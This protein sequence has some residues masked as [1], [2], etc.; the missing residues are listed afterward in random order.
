MR[1]ERLLSILL[2]LQVHGRM[3]AKELARRLEVSERTIHRDMEAL[4]AAGVPVTAVRGTGGGWALLEG[5]ETELTGLNQEEVQALFLA[6]SSRA[7]QDLGMHQAWSAAQIR[8]MAALPESARRDAEFVRQRILV[9]GAPRSYRVSRVKGATVTAEPAERPPNFDL[10]TFWSAPAS[11]FVTNL[12][13]FMV[14]LRVTADLLRHLRYKLRFAQV[15]ESVQPEGADWATV[16]IRFQTEEEACEQILGLGPQ[17]VV[18][19]PPSL[20]EKVLALAA[21]VV[22]RYDQERSRQ[23]IPL[24]V[25]GSL[26]AGGANAHLLSPYVLTVEPARLD[27]MQLYQVDP[28]YPGMV[29]GNGSVVGELVTIAP[30][31]AEEAFRVLDALEEY[32]GPGDPRNAYDRRLVEVLDGRGA[33]RQAWVYIWLGAVEGCSPVPDGDWIRWW[34]PGK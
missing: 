15:E 28:C 16:V 34:Q 23:P 25:Y 22:A 4:S 2:L 14:R 29:P 30:D 27:G 8:L 13:R 5:D 21:Q 20:R 18:E 9:D 17:A 10:A 31:W 3:T 11:Q 26:R 33:L 32:F 24:F 7:V 6:D 1:G 12:P 19:D